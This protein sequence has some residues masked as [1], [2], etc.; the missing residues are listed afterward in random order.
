M[1]HAFPHSQYGPCPVWHWPPWGALALLAGLLMLLGSCSSGGDGGQV[2][3]P[4]TPS[5]ALQ[6]HTV[7]DLLTLYRTALVQQDIDRL[8]TLLQSDPPLAPMRPW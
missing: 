2:V 3:P 1:L 7:A 4:T 5:P 6:Q 8:D